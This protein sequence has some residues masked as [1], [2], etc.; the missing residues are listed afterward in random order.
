[1]NAV[2]ERFIE[3][4][5]HPE[6]E[7]KMAQVLAETR[8]SGGEN[9]LREAL[10]NRWENLDA[11]ERGMIW[12]NIERRRDRTEQQSETRREFLELVRQMHVPEQ[13]QAIP[14]P[15]Q[16]EL[17]AAATEASPRARTAAPETVQ[18]RTED[19][20]TTENRESFLGSVGTG[21]EKAAEKILPRRWTEHMS[22]KQKIAAITAATA[23]L[24]VAGILLWK[25]VR[26]L[27]G[28]GKSAHEE[29]SEAAEKSGSWWKKILVYGAVGTAAFFGIRWL[30]DYIRKNFS[31]EGAVAEAK[32]LAQAAKN[33]AESLVQREQP[34][35][36]YGLNTQQ[37]EKA[38]E[39]YR[40]QVRAEDT[41]IR[42]NGIDQI[43]KI[44]AEA[45]QGNEKF[46]EFMNN[47]AEKYESRMEG[48]TNYM[49]M[50]VA[51]ENYKR[52]M[53]TLVDTL[54]QWIQENPIKTG[55]V[56]AIGYRLGVLK[57]ALTA[58]KLTAKCAVDLGKTLLRLGVRHP[59]ISLL[60]VGGSIIALRE[61]MKKT[62]GK[63]W[64][65]ENTGALCAAINGQKSIV[66]DNNDLN[67]QG[68]IDTIKPHAQKLA[69][70][71]N[72]IGAWITAQ[73]PDFLLEMETSI[74][75]AMARSEQETIIINNVAGMKAL[76]TEL[77]IIKN[78]SGDTENVKQGIPAH[79]KSALEAL[80]IFQEMY[81]EWMAKI[82]A[83]NNAM[84]N[85]EIQ[86]LDEQYNALQGHLNNIGITIQRTENVIRWE[87]NGK[88]RE[89]CAD[90]H[91]AEDTDELYRA[92]EHLKWTDSHVEI[93]ANAFKQRIQELQQYGIDVLNPTENSGYTGL[94]MVLGDFIYMLDLRNNAT[95]IYWKPIEA[96]KGL[97][98]NDDAHEQSALWGKAAATST[99]FAV[100]T[101]P[102]AWI[103]KGVFG[104]S[105]FP[106]AG[107]WAQAGRWANTGATFTLPGVAQTRMIW[108]VP[109]V[110]N[111]AAILKELGRKQGKYVINRLGQARIQPR[112]ILGIENATTM[113]Q[114]R[115][116]ANKASVTNIPENLTLN[117]AKAYV[118]KEVQ[119]NLNTALVTER[120]GLRGK[121]GLG[122]TGRSID[123]PKIYGDALKALRNKWRLPAAG[124]ILRYGV[125][126]ALQGIGVYTAIS[127]DIPAWW[128][129][130]DAIQDAQ[131]TGKNEL[132]DILRWQ[133]HKKTTDIGMDLGGPIAYYYA[134][135]QLSKMA[136]S[137]VSSG[138]LSGAAGAGS[139]FVVLAAVEGLRMET[140]H[141]LN[142]LEENM[143]SIEMDEADVR[144]LS[145]EQLEEKLTEYSRASHGGQLPWG[146][147]HRYYSISRWS[148]GDTW[149]EL[150]RESATV[151]ENYMHGFLF[152]RLLRKAHRDDPH[153][154]GLLVRCVNSDGTEKP[155][156]NR[157]M[158]RYFDDMQ[159]YLQ[160]TYGTRNDIALLARKGIGLERAMHEA[161]M[162]AGLRAEIRACSNAVSRLEEMKIRTQEIAQEMKNIEEQMDQSTLSEEM[163]ALMDKRAQKEQEF[164]ALNEEGMQLM[165]LLRGAQA[166]T[167]KG[168]QGEMTLFELAT[169]KDETDSEVVFARIDT[170]ELKTYM[171]SYQKAKETILIESE[172]PQKRYTHF[173]KEAHSLYERVKTAGKGRSGG[174][175]VSYKPV[176]YDTLLE[177]AYLLDAYPEFDSDKSV[178]NIIRNLPGIR[179]WW[180][181]N[182]A[183]GEHPYE[184][185]FI[186]ARNAIARNLHYVASME[187]DEKYFPTMIE[188]EPT[189]PAPLTSGYKQ[190]LYESA[191]RIQVTVEGTKYQLDANDPAKKTAETPAGTFMYDAKKQSW[192]VDTVGYGKFH[193][194]PLNS[195]G[196]VQP[197]KWRYVEQSKNVLQ[198]IPPNREYAL[199][200]H[201]R[202][203]LTLR[204]KNGTEI[205]SE[206][207]FNGYGDREILKKFHEKFGEYL[208][209]QFVR[210]R[211]GKES[212]YAC[213]FTP[214]KRE[215]ISEIR[216]RS[217]R[218]NL[219][220]QQTIIRFATQSK[221]EAA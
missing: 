150:A 47:M 207:E 32:R 152:D 104:S 89:L 187:H 167:L 85:E 88:T 125:P 13:A 56:A 68:V 70:L 19:T 216:L 217:S 193:M 147:F 166:I 108:S 123:G 168:K 97:V 37:Y 221:K 190:D 117:Q 92:S 178:R 212:Y 16:I 122:A 200:K 120:S 51:F 188:N 24:A 80:E 29:A 91:N 3:A 99:V 90:Y 161:D 202:F 139:G 76:E 156:G 58:G 67:I 64:M 111:E 59:F 210:V 181:Q 2:S 7:N 65:P 115:G 159:R 18:E 204:L 39:L 42:Q 40:I 170:E 10:K 36:K 175:S 112:A 96:W 110:I 196:I 136:I 211:Q 220:G 154:M 61:T 77:E 184:Q 103:K 162:Y 74:A 41:T 1:M 215:E 17:A 79:C 160:H 145:K 69:D 73:M 219:I 45:D 138:I 186:T 31:M 180:D 192:H 169:R 12:S 6:D 109:R 205:A 183:I 38:E 133:R 114:L 50:E 102:L 60:V 208:R 9:E 149:E 63:G 98:T 84:E 142:S 26:R 213:K 118:R 57:A 194:A 129:Y 137:R 66:L 94:A 218:S 62:D 21:M 78:E 34:G 172:E 128:N 14:E 197:G 106:A 105:A 134:Q 191:P 157:E 121:L 164:A 203:Q 165:M 54:W 43:R 100:T 141:I 130:G 158:Q 30:A 75:D 127:H 82:L 163:D 209:L 151:R 189:S 206:K 143:R 176:H 8:E 28:R 131:R 107:R 119:N 95:E 113:R 81:V 22:R 124:R 132:A 55:A 49:R 101:T 11:Q 177:Y 52:D 116:A 185:Q 140:Q 48:G 198:Q 144:K 72:N 201:P 173:K 27:L 71:G 182:P 44:F 35:E 83:D 135:K 214:V 5:R 23:G 25:G 15:E 171:D 33:T 146:Q 126:L 179:G 46:E 86:A 195:L 153:A 199:Y 4:L 53:Q 155:S 148:N 87:N 93:A 20:A 174:G